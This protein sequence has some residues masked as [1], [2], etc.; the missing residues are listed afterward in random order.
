[1]SRGSI[2]LLILL[3]I[4]A[5]FFGI[6][7]INSL[8][9]K[10]RLQNE[11]MYVSPV[12]TMAFYPTTIPPTPIPTDII[13]Q[14]TTTQVENLGPCQT[15]S[16][17]DVNT[18]APFKPGIQEA[19]DYFQRNDLKIDEEKTEI[20]GDNNGYYVVKVPEGSSGSD[21]ILKLRSEGFSDVG[22][23]TVVGCDMIGY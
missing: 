20:I 3:L 9:I 18:G 10:Q 8:Q 7:T 1:M 23:H 12:P 2:V 6:L 21:L 13:T 15:P 16:M 14:K 17:L 22:Y 19:R 4:G 5:A 11:Q